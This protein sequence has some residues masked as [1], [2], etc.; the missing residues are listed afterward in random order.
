VTA[1]APAVSADRLRAHVVELAGTIGARHV[2]R[3]AALAAAAERIAGEWRRQGYEV[4]EQ[5]YV[6][7]GVRCANL[8]VTC[9]GERRPEEIL[10]VGAHYDTVPGSPGADDNASGV[11]ALLELAARFRGARPAV[12]LRFVAF[13]NEEPPFFWLG[14]M[15]SLRYARAARRRGDR[16]LLM[17]SLEMLG[18]YLDEPGAQRYPP[19]M[20]FFRPKAGDFLA[21]VSNRRSR[22]ELRRAATAF[23]AASDFPLQTLAAPAL[24]PGVGWSDHSSFWRQGYPAIMATDTAFYRYP[25]Y[26]TAQDTP[27]KLDYPAMARAVEGLAGMLER[28]AADSS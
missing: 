8:E 24:V 28:L 11:A 18:C 14:E 4:G 25:H 6:A 15:G 5:A 20:R 7:R 19:L 22:R 9:P 2:R 3:P 16:I 26:H 1:P 21:L 13:V 17:V 27:E 23:R 12:S 10:L